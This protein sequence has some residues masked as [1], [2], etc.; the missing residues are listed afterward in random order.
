MPCG[1]QTYAGG[2]V[3]STSPDDL[4]IVHRR[5]PLLAL[6]LSFCN[7]ST[8]P[9][10]LVSF[11]EV[12]NSL[13]TKRSPSFEALIARGIPLPILGLRIPLSNLAHD[14]ILHLAAF[15]MAAVVIWLALI[16]G[17]RG[18]VVFSCWTAHNPFTWV[19][20]GAGTHLVSIF[21]WRVCL[22]PKSHSHS[23][24]IPIRPR[25][26]QVSRWTWSIARSKGMLEVAH[27]KLARFIALF[28]KVLG[29]VNYGYGTVILSAMTL[30]STQNAL[31]VFATMGVMSLGARLITIWL[32]DIFPEL[33]VDE[34]KTGVDSEEGLLEEGS[35]VPEIRQRSLTTA[36]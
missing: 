21:G 4:L 14:I 29:L 10:N 13:Y 28:V 17:S 35:K 15:G 32:V 11:P 25:Q 6:L 12:R 18:I 20:V 19:V 27:P 1:A 36:F 24:R 23:E 22:G 33:Q 34:G 5:W 9:T 16:L 30:V 7:P 8:L 26:H 2:L 31:G 3:T